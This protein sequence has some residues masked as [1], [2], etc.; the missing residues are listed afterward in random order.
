MDNRPLYSAEITEIIGTP[1]RWIMRAGGGLL[2]GG[3]LGLAALA[4]TVRLPEQSTAP[5]LI[6][7]T[8][9]PYYLRQTAGLLRPAVASGQV[10]QQGQLLAQGRLDPGQQVRA[11]FTGILFYDAGAAHAGDTL[12]LLT[13]LANTYRFSGQVALGRVPALR[14]LPALQIEVPLDDH[15]GSLTLRGHLAYIRPDVRGGLVGFA[16]QLDSLSSLTRGRRAAALAT[17]PGQLL[18]SS[19]GKPLAQR[20]LQ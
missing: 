4:S 17:L 7:G 20:L 14:S 13:P 11:P 18:L 1:P 12:G 3:L 10:V 19:P 9:P 2:L 8:V 5:L 15:L 6:R 16:G